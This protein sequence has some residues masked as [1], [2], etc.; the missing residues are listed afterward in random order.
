[1]K[2]FGMEITSGVSNKRLNP[3]W[4]MSHSTKRLAGSELDQARDWPEA[5][6]N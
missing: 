5:L 2:M 6:K 4:M 1:M 3:D